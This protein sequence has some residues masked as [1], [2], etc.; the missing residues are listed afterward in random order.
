MKNIFNYGWKNF[1]ILFCFFL[2]SATIS[3]QNIKIKKGKVLINDKEVFN[4]KTG[5][6]SRG[7]TTSLYSISTNEELIFIKNDDCG[8]YAY[9][10]NN[11]DWDK[12]DFVTYNFLK[13]KVKVEMRGI[14]PLRSNIYVLLNA[15]V[16]DLNGNLNAEKIAQFKDKY[17][18]KIS[19]KTIILK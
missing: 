4:I 6:T 13:Q 7:E 2:F 14:V 19:E 16:F 3:A 10:D 1:I 9:S 18:E 12:D 11:A 17:D 15:E 8:T 5:N